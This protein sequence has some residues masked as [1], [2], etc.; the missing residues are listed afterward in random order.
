M[1]VNY[2]KSKH[3]KIFFDAYSLIESSFYLGKNVLD[4]FGTALESYFVNQCVCP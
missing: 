4:S 2:E 3:P 1:L